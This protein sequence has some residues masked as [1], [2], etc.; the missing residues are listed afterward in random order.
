VSRPASPSFGAM[1]RAARIYLVAVAAAAVVVAVAAGVR[2]AGAPLGDHAL[3]FALLAAGAATAHVLVVHSKRNLSYHT[4]MAFVVPAAIILPPPLLVALVV[5]QHVPEYLRQRYPWYIAVFNVANYVLNTIAAS[6]VFAG[7]AGSSAPSWAAG[8]FAAALTLVV[9]NHLLLAFMLRLGRGHALRESGLLSV[10]GLATD[11]A[12]AALGVAI[13]YF[14]VDNHWL[15]AAAVL[16]LAFLYRALR[17]PALHEAEA[18]QTARA[19]RQTRLTRL[20][21]TAMSGA[22]DHGVL[23]EAMAI[24]RDTLHLPT[25]YLLEC[26]PDGAAGAVE[27]RATLGCTVPDGLLALE[28][29][30]AAA[31]ASCGP[32]AVSDYA[33]NPGFG[34]PS[35]ARAAGAR[36]GIALPIPG[37]GAPAGVLAVFS[38][39]PRAYSGEEIECLQAVATTVSVLIERGRSRRALARSEERRQELLDGMLR[40]EQETRLRI[41]GELHDDTIQI[42]AATL[43]NLDALKGRIERCDRASALDGVARART[44]LTAAIERTRRL[45]FELRP[46]LLERNGLGSALAELV[47]QVGREAGFRA[48]V[49]ADVRRY[50]STIEDL[51]YRIMQEAIANVRKHAGAT[52][53]R[54]E[55]AER[56]GHLCGVVDDDGRGFDVAAALDRSRMRLHLGLDALQERVRLAGGEVDIV[57]ARGAGSRLAFRLPVCAS[58][59]AAAS[60]AGDHGDLAAPPL[61]AAPA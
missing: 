43:M 7:L 48:D 61:A 2:T 18:V 5:I 32:V 17:V 55:L 45:T 1:P 14:A 42:M 27:V 56:D 13:A 60:A 10:D 11:L 33:D 47:E 29:H 57:S 30:D 59:R 12:P 35:A 4:T 50:P 22:P 44:T 34:P 39:A 53:V 20:G 25:A 49:V 40:A 54:A 24:I 37:A 19:E 38:R 6:A 21:L 26:A 41:A 58:A 36:S 46:P 3:A 9:T 23:A 15:I 16:P 51:T 31:V 8:G 52:Y 28:A